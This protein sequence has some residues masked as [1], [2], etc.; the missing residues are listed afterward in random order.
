M[1]HTMPNPKE[2]LLRELGLSVNEAKVYLALLR[3]GCVSA[4]KI[5]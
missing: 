5:A 3:I 2:D 4:G 1:S